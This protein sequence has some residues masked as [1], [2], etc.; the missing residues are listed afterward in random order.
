MS[1]SP[2]ATQ[3]LIS[4]NRSS[5]RSHKIDT[6]TIHCYAAQ[7]SV[8][9]GLNG[10]H[11]PDRGASCNYVIGYDGEIGLCVEEKDRSWCTGGKDANGNVIRVNGI[12]GGDNDERAITIEV[13]SDNFHPYAVTDAAYKSL[14]RLLIDICKRNNIPELRWKGDKSLVGKPGEQNMTVHRWFAV[15]A[16]PGDYLYERHSQIAAEVNKALVASPAVDPNHQLYRV[17]KAWN[18]PASQ[19]GAF[20]VLS[21]AQA[22]ADSNPGWKVYDWT[23]QCVYPAGSD[24]TEFRVQVSVDNLNI[25]SGPGTDYRKTGKYTGVGTFTIVETQPGTG[26]SSG[27]GKLKSGAGWIALDYCKQLP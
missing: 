4:P 17:R 11:D 15:K 22:L 26:S 16:C 18:N 10:F 12:S 5:P 14:I 9:R 1:N 8:K 3:C 7:V 24:S 23:G 2:L 25:R 21:R 20:K 13:A 6:I 19:L 27:W